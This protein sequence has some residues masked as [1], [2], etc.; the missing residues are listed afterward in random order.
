MGRAHSCAVPSSP[1][2]HTYGNIPCNTL[3]RRAASTPEALPDFLVAAGV[4]TGLGCPEDADGMSGQHHI[5]I[6]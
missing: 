2:A 4:P 5:L 1:S 6:C 3:Q